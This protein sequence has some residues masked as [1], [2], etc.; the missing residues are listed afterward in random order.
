[1]IPILALIAGLGV[2]AIERASP[3]I[4]ILNEAE[5]EMEREI[6]IGDIAELTGFHAEEERE[7]RAITLGEAPKAGEERILTHAALSVTL[8]PYLARLQH[9]RTERIRLLLPPLMKIRRKTFR[10]E[11]RQIEA[12]LRTRVLGSCPSCEVE[13]TRLNLPVLAKDITAGSTWTLRE[14]AEPPKGSFSLPLEIISPNGSR[15]LYWITGEARLWR[16]VPV[17]KRSLQLG[18]R[19]T[20]GDHAIERR[21]VTFASDAFPAGSE[22][23]GASVARQVVAGSMIGR[24]MIRHSRAVRSGQSVK[25]VSGNPGWQVSADGVSQQD[26]FA[27]DLIRVRVQRTQKVVSG[28]L[29]EGGVVELR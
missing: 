19:L 22:I 27:G 10:L 4:R 24:S 11:A 18:E 9:R 1:M 28:V 16:Q 5:V 17:A 7:L 8:R 20:N 26:G 6:T 2:Q 23:N 21:D 15:R 14:R 12:E 25:V 3:E 29:S 13:F